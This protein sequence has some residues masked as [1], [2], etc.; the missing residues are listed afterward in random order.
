[1]I[2]VDFQQK[3]NKHSFSSI[4]CARPIPLTEEWLLKLGFEKTLNQYRIE[5]NVNTRNGNNVPFIILD[6]DGFEYDDL[7]LQTKIKYV[8]H[9]QNLY[10]ALTGE[11]LTI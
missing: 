7:R 11:E 8:N 9:L 10:F 6:I 5:T 1:M 4:N 2:M 3:N